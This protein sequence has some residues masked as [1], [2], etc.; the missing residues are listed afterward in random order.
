MA[1][2]LAVDGMDVV[3]LDRA[4]P[5]LPLAEIARAGRRASGSRSTWRT[6]MT[7]PPPSGAARRLSVDPPMWW[8][9]T[10]ALTRWPDS[11]TLLSTRGE[12]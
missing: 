5:T 7:L 11:R 3:M 9:P 2:R 1:V 8:C 6:R 4:E 10:S 12:R